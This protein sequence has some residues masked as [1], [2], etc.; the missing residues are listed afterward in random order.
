VEVKRVKHRSKFLEIT[1]ESYGM[2]SEDI[3]T[4]SLTHP[5]PSPPKISSKL[6]RSED[7]PRETKNLAKTH[8]S[9]LQ[10]SNFVPEEMWVLEGFSLPE[11]EFGVEG[12]ARGATNASR[13]KLK[14][15]P[16]PTFRGTNI[17]YLGCF[18]FR[19]LDRKDTKDI[20]RLHNFLQNPVL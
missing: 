4:C 12:A 6:F 13:G 8:F 1:Q 17:S 20:L 10:I 3:M 16:K 15:L 11:G 19:G 14:T 2:I 18:L 5:D 9:R 7:I